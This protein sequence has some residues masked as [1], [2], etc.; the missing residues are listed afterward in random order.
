DVVTLERSTGLERYISVNRNGTDALA[1]FD[2]FPPASGNVA[3]Q[4]VF[5]GCGFHDAARAKMAGAGWPLLWV[6]GDVCSGSHVAG[7]QAFSLDGIPIR[8][9]HLENGVVGPSWS[10]ADADYCLLAGILPLDLKADRYSQTRACFER[11]EAGVQKTGMNFLHVVRTWFFLDQLL[12]WYDVF[13]KARTDFFNERGV[14]DHLVPAST[15]IGAG[16]PAGAAL[17]AG[18]LAIKPK[19]GKVTIQEVNS[20]LQCPATAY[21]SSFARATEITYSD[22]RQLIVSGTASIA[23]GGETM[24]QDDIVKQIHLTLDVI[25]AILKSRGMDWKD[26]VRAVGYFHDIRELPQFNECLRARGIAE[27]PMAP[28]HATVCRHDLLFEMELDAIVPV[29]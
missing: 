17:S 16:N 9:I 12:D 5:G 25:E 4:L 19:N 14:F 13:N 18:A 23:P 29:K 21:R 10:D 26:T 20:P 11:I 27:F 7:V 24:Y 8:R 15:G 2:D 1:I 3:A 22:R 6:Q 28:A